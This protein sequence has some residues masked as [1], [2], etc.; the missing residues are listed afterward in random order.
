MRLKNKK[1]HNAK[2]FPENYAIQQ[3]DLHLM[4]N[5][6]NLLMIIESWLVI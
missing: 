4:N 3:S 2:I 6:F 1:N 5:I